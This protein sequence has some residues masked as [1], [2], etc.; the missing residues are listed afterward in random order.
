M[1]ND[2]LWKGD[3]FLFFAFIK[4]KATRRGQ[5]EERGKGENNEGK[6]ARK[7]GKRNK[8]NKMKGE[9]KSRLLD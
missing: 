9:T 4:N 3:R 5:R 8:K 1:T 2:L 6:K 7:K